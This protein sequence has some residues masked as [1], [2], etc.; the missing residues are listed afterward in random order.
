MKSKKAIGIA[1]LSA[2]LVIAVVAVA[3]AQMMH[4]QGGSCHRGQFG[5]GRMAA[6]LNLT[7]EQQTK[8]RDIFQQ[9]KKDALAVF[10]PE[11]QQQIAQMRKDHMGM[12]GRRGQF[13]Q[14][15]NLTPEQKTKMQAIRQDARTKMQAVKN[16]AALS[17]DE[18]ITQMRAIR[19]SVREQMQQVL[20]PEQQKQIQ[21]R[22]QQGPAQKLNLTDAQKAQ[23]KSI[24]DKAMEQFRGMLTP[25]QQK[26]FD[27]ARQQMQQR[28][29]QFRQQHQQPAK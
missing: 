11:Q 17:Q 7:P 14:S 28:M 25:E 15:L 6:R 2:V 29:E 1:L 12:R 13:L 3:G 19:Q 8:A 22:F 16:N 18:K 10:T 27:Q 26:S 21:Q 20:T 9:A 5:M 24:R 23:L 4:R